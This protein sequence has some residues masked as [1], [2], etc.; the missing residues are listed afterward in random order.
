M[1]NAILAWSLAFMISVVLLVLSGYDTIT[2]PNEAAAQKQGN[3]TNVLV[4][5]LVSKSSFIE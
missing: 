3:T 1:F 5:R 4:V 2:F